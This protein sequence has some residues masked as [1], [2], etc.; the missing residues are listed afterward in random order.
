MKKVEKL[1]EER[2]VIVASDL[3]IILIKDSKVCIVEIDNPDWN[4]M[5]KNLTGGNRKIQI[6][7]MDLLQADEKFWR[8]L[9]DKTYEENKSFILEHKL[10]QFRVY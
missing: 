6:T 5:M 8:S 9:I 4:F 3:K 7:R 1:T 10:N 2:V